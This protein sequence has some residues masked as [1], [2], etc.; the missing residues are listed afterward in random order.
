M[1]S[2]YFLAVLF[3]VITALLLGFGY[4]NNQLNKGLWPRWL[5]AFCGIFFAFSAMFFGHADTN[6]HW[7]IPAMSLWFAV[8]CVF[9]II[10]SFPAW[11][12]MMFIY[13]V[14][15]LE[16]K[17]PETP[18]PVSHHDAAQARM[19]AETPHDEDP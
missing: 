10:A 8:H 17:I 5:I 2:N 1:E 14:F 13:D 18:K 6:G 11:G 4:K 7:S 9:T 3:G 15:G 16:E 19:A 12:L